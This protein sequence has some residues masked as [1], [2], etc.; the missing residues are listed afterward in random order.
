M[1]LRIREIL[2]LLLHGAEMELYAENAPV[3]DIPALQDDVKSTGRLHPQVPH[4]SVLIL[5]F[6]KDSLR[7][8]NEVLTGVA[9]LS[10]NGLVGKVNGGLVVPGKVGNG[11]EFK[12]GDY[13]DIQG[14]FPTR[15]KPRTLV[16]W[17]KAGEGEG[18]RCIIT[19]GH[20]KNA[21]NRVFGLMIAGGNW[22]FYDNFGG[23]ATEIPAD[24]D[25][26]PIV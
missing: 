3:D 8:E 14:D 25:W 17:V 6:E 26:H 24:F 4:G 15:R 5:T 16:A 23:L 22:R 12:V 21:K 13:I 19:Y 7:Q 9:D 11:I 2:N 10:G 18:N 20:C 1:S